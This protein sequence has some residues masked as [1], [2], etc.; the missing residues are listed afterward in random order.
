MFLIMNAARFKIFPAVLSHLFLGF[1]NSPI[2]KMM[3]NRSFFESL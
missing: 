3:I 2:V 1:D